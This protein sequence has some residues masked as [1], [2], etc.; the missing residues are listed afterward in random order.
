MTFRNLAS[1]KICF[2]VSWFGHIRRPYPCEILESV[3][4]FN[5]PH[6]HLKSGNLFT[7]WTWIS[8]WSG[9]VTISKE[10][11][12]IYCSGSRYVEEGPWAEDRGGGWHGDGGPSVRACAQADS[13][14][15]AIHRGGS[16]ALEGSRLHSA[17]V[18]RTGPASAARRE[19]RVVARIASQSRGCAPLRKGSW[20]AALAL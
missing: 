4:S 1:R 7:S 10:V 17:D 3:D 19:D 15:V 8:A 16:S 11:S 5:C 14:C 2:A 20:C 13:V 9:L 12:V 18:R 6:E